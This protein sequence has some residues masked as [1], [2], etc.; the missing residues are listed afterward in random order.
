MKVLL[1]ELEPYFESYW[2]WM[3]I[4]GKVSGGTPEALSHMKEM[5]LNIMIAGMIHGVRKGVSDSFR[6]AVDEL[7]RRDESFGEI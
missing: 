1:D 2:S 4:T 5:A 7:E 3:L 6:E